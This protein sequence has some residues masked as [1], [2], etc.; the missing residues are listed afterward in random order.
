MKLPSF[1]RIIT[2]DFDKE[3]QKLVEDL[4][5]TINDSFNT[6]YS[7]LNK[8]LTF[9]DNIMCTVREITVTVDSSGN[10]T[11]ASSFTLDVPNVPVSGVIVLNASNLTNSAI[12][13]VSQPCISFVQVSNSIRIINITGLQANNLY[14]IKLIALN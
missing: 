13:P 3:F 4:G 7:A 14:R 12:Y 9:N 11:S 5:S 1:R 10:P 8:R 6:I 2:T